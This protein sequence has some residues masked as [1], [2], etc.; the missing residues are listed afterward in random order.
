MADL[1]DLSKPDLV[2]NYSTEVLQ[3]IRGHITRLW[4]G[5]YTGM[6]GLVANMRRWVDL[7]G[8]NAKLV[9]RNADGS[10]TT[11]FDSST[12]VSQ[13]YVDT[14]VSGEATARASAVT[15]EA[16]SRATA[17]DNEVAN[18]NTAIS[19][20]ATARANADALKA[21][22]TGGNATGT[23]P[24]S[25]TG[26]SA[27]GGVKSVNGQTDDVTVT[28]SYLGSRGQVF[29]SSGTFTPTTG[30]TAVKFTIISGGGS[31][32]TNGNLGGG[33]GAIAIGFATGLGGSVA[34][35]VGAGGAANTGT[36][37]TGGAS[38]F[39]GTSCSGGGSGATG[40]GGTVTAGSN[41]I[42]FS[43]TGGSA[44][45]QTG[46][47][48]AN[49]P[50]LSYSIGGINDGTTA[51]QGTGYGAG[52]ASGNGGGRDGAAGRAGVVILEW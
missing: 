36:G 5:D 32:S 17:I 20:E 21:D 14:A 26:N 15:N 44:V 37:N 13:S 46:G 42:A 40:A 39:N 49:V 38:S 22:K 8:G 52:G 48:G 35:T 7:G 4:T 47:G 9:K 6:G 33:G 2:S 51:L 29:T 25:I 28:S 12:K 23:W 16:S 27:N 34:V 3:T 1:N 43:S 18:R 41:T 24:I 50:A 19:A 45:G 30:I 11:I 31:G 10:E